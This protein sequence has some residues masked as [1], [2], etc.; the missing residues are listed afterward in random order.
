MG[1]VKVVPD[2]EGVYQKE[3]LVG[4]SSWIIADGN[5]PHFRRGRA[6]FALAFFP[7]SSP[8]DIPRDW[9]SINPP[10]VDR[11]SMCHIEGSEYL[12]TAKVTHVLEDDSWWV[13]DAG[14]LMYR[15]G[16]PPDDIEPGC[17]VSGK[18][19]VSID[20]FDYFERLSRY[21]AAP[22]LIYDWDVTKIELETTPIVCSCTVGS[23]AALRMKRSTPASLRRACWQYCSSSHGGSHA[24]EQPATRRINEGNG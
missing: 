14:V 15:Y 9:L 16:K 8:I 20:P 3:M 13:I 12:V 4:L 7:A 22:P 21:Y 18:L 10:D 2:L 17:W 6:S 5:Y 11:T 19:Y 24:R 1:M 23:H